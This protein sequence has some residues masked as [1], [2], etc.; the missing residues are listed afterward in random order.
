MVDGQLTLHGVTRPVALDLEF[1]G[2]GG[3][4]WGNTRAGFTATAEINRRDFGIDITMPLETGGVVVGDKIK[5]SIDVELVLAAVVE[6][7]SPRV[8]GRLAPAGRPPARPAQTGT[9]Q[10]AL[11]P[12]L[13]G[14]LPG[15]TAGGSP[16]GG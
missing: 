5:L 2:V 9:R 3:D 11:L 8:G 4:P 7:R 14:R 13:V 12:S 15:G 1:N 16:R 10:V 6:Q